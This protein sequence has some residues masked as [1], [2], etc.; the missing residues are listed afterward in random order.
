M[1]RLKQYSFII[2][3]MAVVVTACGQK[4]FITTETGLDYLKVR[5]GSGEKPNDGEYLMLNV[6]YYDANEIGRA[7]CR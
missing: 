7:S 5:E 3:F 4:E 1:N 2:V 6:A